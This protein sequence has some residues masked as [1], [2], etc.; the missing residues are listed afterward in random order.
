[1]SDGCGDMATNL[2]DAAMNEDV[3]EVRRVVAAGADV[4]E[5]RASMKRGHCTRQQPT[6]RW[7]C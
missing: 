2:S 5:Q 7:R 4:E 3:V 1:V 6:G